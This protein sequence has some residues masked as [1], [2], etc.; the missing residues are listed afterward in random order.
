MKKNTGTLLVVAAVILAG[1]VTLSYCGSTDAQLSRFNGG[2]NGTSAFYDQMERA[3][4]AAISYNTFS[5]TGDPG[6]IILA[7]PSRIP[8]ETD[9]AHIRTFVTDGG[10]LIVIAKNESANAILNAAGSSIRILTRRENLNGRF[11]YGRR[12]FFRVHGNCS[13]GIFL[14]GSRFKG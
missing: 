6:T 13:W 4:H 12:R 10:T 1:I 8:E 3:G 11:R 9:G 5:Q 14:L 7:E 2:W